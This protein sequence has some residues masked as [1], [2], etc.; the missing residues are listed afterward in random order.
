MFLYLKNWTGIQKE[1][2][3]MWLHG[4]KESVEKQL[5]KNTREPTGGPS[6]TNISNDHGCHKPGEDLGFKKH[7]DDQTCRKLGEHSM[8]MAGD[9][10]ECQLPQKDHEG[11]DWEHQPD[12]THAL[13]VMVLPPLFVSMVLLTIVQGVSPHI[14]IYIYIHIYI[15]ISHTSPHQNHSKRNTNVPEIEF[16][17]D[18]MQCICFSWS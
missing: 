17:K 3:E 4:C 8:P 12:P 1:T 5:P 10:R 15:Y 7:Q 6:N 14:Y 16:V 2:K 13:K 9:T 11:H 18:R